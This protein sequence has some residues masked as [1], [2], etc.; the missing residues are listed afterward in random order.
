MVLVRAT[1]QAVKLQECGILVQ[2]RFA[3]YDQVHTVGTDVAHALTAGAALT[4][5]K[6]MT[7]RDFAQGAYRMRGL[8]RGQR[9]DVFI[10]PEVRDLIGRELGKV[11]GAP[12]PAPDAA[13]SL[14]AV[15]G[16]LLLNS[17]R[18]ERVQYHT[19]QLQNVANAWRKTAF[20][21]LTE[22]LSQ[23]SV[24]RPL[25]DEALTTALDTFCE[26]IDFALQPGIPMPQSMSALVEG[27]VAAHA[28]LIPGAERP[29]VDE[30]VRQ[31][32]AAEAWAKDLQDGFGGEAS[33]AV[34]QQQEQV[35]LRLPVPRHPHPLF[36]LPAS[37]LVRAFS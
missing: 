37:A 11:A 16:W 31:L 20:R 3:F 22:G 18:V 1:G 35:P 24:T 32:R 30:V 8:G 34:E 23:F 12:A 6:D 2:H 33:L 5:G 14:A 27:K 36:M 26:R 29:A 21:A 19:L 15:S 17:M 28:A 10:I 25:A 9:V 13:L 4:L 7:F